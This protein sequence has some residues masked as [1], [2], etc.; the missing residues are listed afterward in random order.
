MQTLM[1]VMYF[2]DALTVGPIKININLT[3]RLELL[4]R[5]KRNIVFIEMKLIERIVELKT[6]LRMKSI[7]MIAYKDHKII[8]R[9][10][11]LL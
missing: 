6:T 11:Q 2:T 3:A 5:L 7:A 4:T 8:M 9:L 1:T 10:N